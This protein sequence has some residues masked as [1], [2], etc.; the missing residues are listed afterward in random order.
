MKSMTGYG[1]EERQKDGLSVSVEVKSYNGRFLDISCALPSF[2]SPLESGI[3]EYIAS[4]SR[5]GKVEVFVRIKEAESAVKIHVNGKAAAAYYESVLALAKSLKIRKKPGLSLILGMEGVM[6]AEK[7]RDI[8]AC[9]YLVNAALKAAFEKFDGQR[10]REGQHTKE[11]I[12]SH[13]KTLE[14]SLGRIASR[15]P[16]LENS[17][18][19]NLRRRFAE[20]LNDGVDENR[21]LAETAVLLVKYTIAEE[22]SRL[23]SHLGE[24]RAEAENSGAPG[25]KL[26]FLSQ[27]INREINT[28]GSKTPVLDVS[29]EVVVMKDALENIREQ[30]RNIE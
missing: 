10:L 26:D 17:I 9:E 1:I 21:V 29:R 16:E 15:G 19:E 11:N 12:F 18:R 7:D 23:E 4:R 8:K 2:L 13:I 24:F 28:I 6:E 30:L 27:E 20:L 3:R 25:K 14:D 22:I 5:R